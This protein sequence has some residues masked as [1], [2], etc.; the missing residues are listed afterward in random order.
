MVAQV[1]SQMMI[2]KILDIDIKWRII[3]YN[4][5]IILKCKL[6][7]VETVEVE[8]KINRALTESWDC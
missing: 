7:K 4:F 6:N 1:P 5:N 3:A 8:I 2:K